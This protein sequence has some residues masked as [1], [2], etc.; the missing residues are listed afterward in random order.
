MD[1]TV[2]QWMVRSVTPSPE[3]LSVGLRVHYVVLLTN[4]S[5]PA[6][7]T[8]RMTPPCTVGIICTTSNT[9]LAP[10]T[11][12]G[13]VGMSEIESRTALGRV[14][15]S[16]FCARP[17]IAFMQSLRGTRQRRQTIQLDVLLLA[18]AGILL[19]ATLLPQLDADLNIVMKDRTLDV[20]LSA[21]AFVAVAGLAV[22]TFLRY[23]ET[24][25]LASFVQSSAFAL[26]A[27]F[28]LATLLLIVLRLDVPV[29]MTLGAPEQLPAW[30]SGLA[31]VSVSGVL[32]MSSI[33]AIRGIYGGT[34]RRFRTVFLPV[35][36]IAAATI[37]IYPLRDLL[38]ELIEPAG[39]AAIVTPELPNEMAVLPGFTGLALAMVVVTVTGLVAATVLYRLTWGR[40]GPTSDAFTALGLVILAVAEVQYA[41]WP[42]VYTSLVT[43][44]D[45]MRLG[46][47]TVLLAGA[48]ADQRS[49]LRALRSAYTALDRM[50]VNEA[51]RAT[52][53]ERARLARE[54]HDGLAQHLWFAKLKFE[55]LSSTLPDVD[56]TL[57]D[58]VTQA[59]DAAII[60]AR[61]ALV[62]MR[63][64]LEGDVPFVD[65]LL[66]AVDD[67]EDASGLRVEFNVSTGIPSALAPRVQVELLRIISE[68][69]NN[70]RKHADATLVRVV[71]EVADGELLI[72]V[73]DNGHGFDQSEAFDRGMGLQGMRERAHLIGGNLGVRSEISGGTTIEVRAPLV[74]GGIGSPSETS[75]RTAM[76]PSEEPEP[77]LVE[78]FDEL[79]LVSTR[80]VRTAEVTSTGGTT[81]AP[82]ARPS[83]M[84]T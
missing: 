64:S 77:L 32:L 16:P 3:S 17:I 54:I 33:A 15:L 28:T 83:G 12:H 41:L 80:E 53:E 8:A 73:T 21:L 18:T 70:V 24:G 44:S 74:T 78:P 35:A 49:D 58:E 55:R 67:F 51:E 19:V 27:M 56:R 9:A 14:R 60:E 10:L 81:G 57:A 66:R 5:V 25:R 30:V 79:Q 11:L 76:A 59:L 43:L 82:D 40:G 46:A 65:M 37:F 69:L 47:Y 84:Q 20:A 36:V 34:K 23:R 6:S 50:R 4:D 2:L 7:V 68:A 26:W 75:E 71:A 31:R 48:F 1:L 63:S 22:L 29:G 72:K 38:P 61:E 39:L 62:T 45:I 42:S 13:G 52:L